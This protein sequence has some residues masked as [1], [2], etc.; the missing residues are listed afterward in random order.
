LFRKI[1]GPTIWGRESDDRIGSFLAG[2][3]YEPVFVEGSDPMTVH[4]EFAE[5]CFP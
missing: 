1:S 2:H 3:G 5:P 4:Q